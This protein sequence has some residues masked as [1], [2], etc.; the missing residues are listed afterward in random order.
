MLI[1]ILKSGLC[2]TFWSVP[3]PSMQ[4]LCLCN[5]QSNS[6]AG[7]E[8]FADQP[9]MLYAGPLMPCGISPFF[10]YPN[11]F[12]RPLHFMIYINHWNGF[13]DPYNRVSLKRS[14]D[15]CLYFWSNL[16]Y[17]I[18]SSHISWN[19]IYFWNVAMFLLDKQDNCL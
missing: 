15:P 1:F 10:F 8:G 11:I 19:T 12:K 18:Q 9:N 13:D 7:I 14:I 3:L 16:Y 5:L 17:I 6:P 4:C 2:D